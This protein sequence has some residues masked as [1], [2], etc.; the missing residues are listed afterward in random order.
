MKITLQASFSRTLPPDSAVVG[1]A[2]KRALL[3]YLRASIYRNR[4]YKSW[5]ISV[6]SYYCTEIARINL[7]LS[8]SALISIREAFEHLCTEVARPQ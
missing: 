5:A 3:N 7:A 2:I 1:Y 6:R 8:A 4:S